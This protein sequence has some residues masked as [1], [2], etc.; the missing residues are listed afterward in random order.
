MTL[1]ILRSTQ[2]K[3]DLKK[4]IKQRK[5]LEL[6]DDVIEKLR[7]VEPLEFKHRDH[8]LVG[9]WKGY[10]ECHINPDW[11]LIYKVDEELELLRLM[12]TGSHAD[13]FQ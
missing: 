1:D 3:K 8:L 12:R 5:N 11:L 6:L 7:H 4:I 2:F 10:R 13:L 9:D